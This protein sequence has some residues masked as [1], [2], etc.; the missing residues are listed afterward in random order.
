M[1]KIVIIPAGGKGVRSGQT[2]PK[3]FVRVKGKELIIYTLETFQKNRLVDEIIVSTDRHYFGLLDKLKKKYRLT[4]LTG[5]V[6]GGKRRQDSVYNAL[7]SVSAAKSDLIIVH[8]A[9]RPLLPE[10]TLTNAIRTAENRGNAVVCLSG[11]NTLIKGKK[12][13]EDYI[14]RENVYYV[15][16]PQIFKYGDLKQA[17]EKAYNENF[18]ATDESLLIK[19]L[20]RKV[21]ITEGSNLNFKVTTK[22]D[23]QLFKSLVQ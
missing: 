9:A 13:I 12:Y 5:I 16:T 22:E 18:Y 10:K 20:G 15:Q 7:S 19:R 14:P 17:M 2:L 23:F 11:Y 4:K 3:Q 6:E 1:K 21:N 8:D